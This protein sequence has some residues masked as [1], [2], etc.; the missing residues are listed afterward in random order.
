M[1]QI[2]ALLLAGLLC[3]GAAG[4]VQDRPEPLAAGNEPV[5]KTQPVFDLIVS[6]QPISTV[7]EKIEMHFVNNTGK[8]GC[9]QSIPHLERLSETGEWVEV[10]WK[11]NIGF[12]GTPDPLP[13]E[14]RDWS[15]NIP[16]LWGALEEGQYRL[17]YKVGRGYEPE[18]LVYGEFF[19]S[20]PEMCGYPTAE[21]F[22]QVP[23]ED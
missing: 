22:A 9:V 16:L 1:T 14:G 15:E 5:E 2:I 3:I 4:C 17:Y 8:E 19:V 11:D 12:C 13:V 7:S 18:E 10:P 21:R 6:D 20:T 23:V